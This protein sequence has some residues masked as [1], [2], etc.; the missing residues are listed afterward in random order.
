MIGLA[1][2]GAAHDVLYQARGIILNGIRSSA[3]YVLWMMV[4][5][6]FAGDFQIGFEGS[7]RCMNS[8]W[9]KVRWPAPTR[10]RQ[11]SW[12]RL[13]GGQHQSWPDGRRVQEQF[14]G[15]MG[16]ATRL[17]AGKTCSLPSSD[18]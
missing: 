2:N 10:V 16:A 14:Q 1:S 11:Q 3:S 12:G 5:G 9:I 17:H 18:A 4:N 7:R 6:F 15:A 8:R 13:A